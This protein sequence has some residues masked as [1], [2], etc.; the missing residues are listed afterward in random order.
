[1]ALVVFLRG[2]NVGGHR[3]F[4]PSLLAKKLAKHNVINV[5]AAGTFVVM[6]P[7]NQA[8]LRHELLRSLP[9]EADIMFCSGGDL[10]ELVSSDPFAGE[11]SG[12]DVVRFVSVLAK[13]PRVLPALPLSLP[14]PDNW[15]LKIIE[16]RGRFALGL[17]RR[18]MRAITLLSQIER[19]FGVSTTTR[20]W[21]TI[22][23]IAET[24]KNKRVDR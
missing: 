11:P 16:V 5:G 14:A 13:R 6:K 4:Q 17:Y 24:L 9:L 10:I 22:L 1:M 3:T 12:S 21:N 7:I 2:V 23:T 20:N 19:R 15:L 18:M 8:E